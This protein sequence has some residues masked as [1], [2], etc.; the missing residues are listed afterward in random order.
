M[1]GQDCMSTST[2]STSA[3]ANK[4]K[5]PGWL[6]AVI[7]IVLVVGAYTWQQRNSFRSQEITIAAAWDSNKPVLDKVTQ[8][9]KGAGLAVNEYTD[10]IVKAINTGMTGRYGPAG[11]QAAVQWI[12]ENQPNIDSAVFLKLQQIIQAN[13]AE[14]AAAQITLRDRVRVY[15]T[16]TGQGLSGIVASVLG[17]PRESFNMALYKRMIVTADTNETFDT[18]KLKGVDELLGKKN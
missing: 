1:E 17:Y 10:L 11:S 14:W 16:D 15:E 4:A 5:F 6:I 7:G 2:Q 8:N 3:S 13:Y 18:G 12:R 9:I